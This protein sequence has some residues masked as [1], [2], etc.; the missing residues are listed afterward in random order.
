MA[1]LHHC[2]ARMSPNGMRMVSLAVVLIG[3]PEVGPACPLFSAPIG[4]ARRG[5]SAA[6]PAG[7]GFRWTV[8]TKRS[9][10]SFRSQAAFS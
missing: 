4:N 3:S 6:Q 10:C 2:A 5:T 7:V 9:S 8:G 1:M